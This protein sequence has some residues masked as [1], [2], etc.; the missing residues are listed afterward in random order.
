MGGLAAR[1]AGALFAFPPTLVVAFLAWGLVG[2]V[3]RYAIVG[4]VVPLLASYVLVTALAHLLVLLLKATG[5]AFPPTAP[6]AVAAGAVYVVL[7]TVV[8]AVLAVRVVSVVL[9]NPFAVIVGVLALVLF[10]LPHLFAVASSY[11][12]AAAYAPAAPFNPGAGTGGVDRP[13]ECLFRGVLI[14]MNAAMNLILAYGIVHVYVSSGFVATTVPA[15]APVGYAPGLLVAAAVAAGVLALVTLLTVL[16]SFS[17]PFG[18]NAITDGLQI[19]IERLAGGHGWLMPMMLFCS[20]DGW[21]RFYASWVCH[22]AAMIVAAAPA[23]WRIARVDIFTGNI[24]TSGGAIASLTIPAYANA[25]NCGCF[26]FVR[27]ARARALSTAQHETGHYLHGVS[28]GSFALWMG[29]LDGY[30]RARQNMRGID[31]YGERVAESNV[32]PSRGRPE[33]PIWD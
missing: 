5:S 24:L 33:V 21:V 1:L 26:S 2:E 30:E 15:G 7:C 19:F 20:V 9:A 28:S 8:L 22:V 10:F 32:R 3:A 4:I 18:R 17:V 31:A 12:L 25:Y 11:V 16:T 27:R 14:G 6:G 13:A 23:A 29:F